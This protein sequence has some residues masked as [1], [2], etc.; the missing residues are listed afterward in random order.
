LGRVPFWVLYDG[1]SDHPSQHRGASF[2]NLD[3]FCL[4]SSH[5]QI[6]FFN[7]IL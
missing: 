5:S 2:H 4:L 7:Q 3:F 6:Y 1:S